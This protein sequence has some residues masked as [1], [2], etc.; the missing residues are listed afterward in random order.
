MKIDESV[1]LERIEKLTKNSE[2]C[3]HQITGENRL[4]QTNNSHSIGIWYQVLVNNEPR[5][6]ELKS[7]IKDNTET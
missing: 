6:D 2:W 5:I 3:V 4:N 1:I 7:L